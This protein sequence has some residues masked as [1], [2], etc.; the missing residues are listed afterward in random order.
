MLT[1][2][3]WVI[4]NKKRAVLPHLIGPAG[5]EIFDTLSD[6]GDNYEWAIASLDS[7]FMPKINLIY[8]RYNFLSPRQNSA[9]IIDFLQ[10]LVTMVVSK[11]KWLGITLWWA[12]FRL[13][14]GGVSCRRRISLLNISKQFPGQWNWQIIRHQKW[15]QRDDS[16]NAIKRL[17][18]DKEDNSNDRNRNEML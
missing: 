11:R 10:N 14:C 5:Q 3:V 2:Q 8:E 13:V 1:Q 7:Y 9:E 15:R 16:I 18:I 17:A 12:A 6:T 4:I